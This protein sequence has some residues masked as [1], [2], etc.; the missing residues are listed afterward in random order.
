MQV[1]PLEPIAWGR[2]GAWEK[3]GK[4]PC[5]LKVVRHEVRA[6]FAWSSV[7]FLAWEESVWGVRER[8]GLGWEEVAE[9]VVEVGEVHGEEM[10]GRLLLMCGR[11]GFIQN[12]FSISYY[13]HDMLLIY[14]GRHFDSSGA[15]R[16]SR[17]RHEGLQRIIGA[18]HQDTRTGCEFN[19]S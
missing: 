13:P 7:A 6:M 16:L 15:R 10:K 17:S 4:G 2:D 11:Q 3:W 19:Q 12:D 8:G 5:M 18:V 9:R 1:D 14:D